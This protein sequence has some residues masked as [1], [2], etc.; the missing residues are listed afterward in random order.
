MGKIMKH[1]IILLIMILLCSCQV[2]YKESLDGVAI[3]PF[4]KGVTYRDGSEVH[5][6]VDRRKWV[7]PDRIAFYFWECHK[8][9]GY[10]RTR[11]N[12]KIGYKYNLEN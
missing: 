11:G 5:Y 4:C 3:C 1:I 7:D 2:A 6:E 12:R 8:C 9:N 10:Y